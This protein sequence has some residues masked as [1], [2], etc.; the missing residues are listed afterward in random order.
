VIVDDFK[1]LFHCVLLSKHLV[2][3]S[4]TPTGA[5]LK[6]GNNQLTAKWGHQLRSLGIPLHRDDLF[7]RIRLERLLELQ[8]RDHTHRETK[9]LC[10]WDWD[11]DACD[12]H[13]CK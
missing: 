12:E 1:F 2:A 13:L 7:A 8:F 10:T 4:S 11:S 3:Y 6:I 5:T 9:S